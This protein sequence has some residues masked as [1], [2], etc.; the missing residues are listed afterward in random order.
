MGFAEDLD[1]TGRGLRSQTDLLISCRLLAS[2]ELSLITIFTFP[3]VLGVYFGWPYAVRRRIGKWNLLLGG[4]GIWKRIH[5][6]SRLNEILMV[7]R[8]VTCSMD[9]WHAI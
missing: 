4:N 7:I 3:E 8:L 9:Y 6:R 1:G 5:L 2:C